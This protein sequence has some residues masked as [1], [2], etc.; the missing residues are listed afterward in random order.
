MCC[1]KKNQIT[2]YTF[3]LL[4]LVNALTIQYTTIHLYS[5]Y[6]SLFMLLNNIYI[7]FMLACQKA[8]THVNKYNLDI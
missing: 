4:T 2:L 3:H 5:I 7:F 1:I 6:Q 8:L